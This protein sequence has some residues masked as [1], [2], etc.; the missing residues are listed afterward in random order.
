[1]E[2]LINKKVKVTYIDEMSYKDQKLLKSLNYIVTIEDVDIVN[3]IL[4]GVY[5]K[6]IKGYLFTINQIKL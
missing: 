6:E 5:S 1:M 4:L 3:G 2:N